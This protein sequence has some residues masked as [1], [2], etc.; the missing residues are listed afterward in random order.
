MAGQS[1]GQA[2]V[3]PIG[4]RVRA[5]EP[6]EIHEGERVHLHHR[7]H[8][9]LPADIADVLAPSLEGDCAFHRLHGALEHAERAISVELE[10]LALVGL[11]AAGHRLL[12]P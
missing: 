8:L 10:Q 2:V 7:I 9:E 12:M 6:Y 5:R 11:D 3:E 4:Q 1:R